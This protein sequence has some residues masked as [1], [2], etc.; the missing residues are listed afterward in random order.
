MKKA[1]ADLHLSHRGMA[2]YQ[3]TERPKAGDAA[4]AELY[5]GGKSLGLYRGVIT[6]V[7]ED[8]AFQGGL[9]NV[10]R[11]RLRLT[12]KALLTASC[13]QLRANHGQ[14]PFQQTNEQYTA[15]HLKTA[16]QL[17]FRR[18][19]DHERGRQGR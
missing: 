4:Y 15:Y 7:A 17:I 11:C 16:S 3:G 18:R 8:G 12:D 14:E 1:T 5:Q 6:A 13:P 9:W 10:A 2:Y 19:A